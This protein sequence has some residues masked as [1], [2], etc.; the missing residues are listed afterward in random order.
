MKKIWLFVL[1]F[2]F[3]LGVLAQGIADDDMRQ[4]FYGAAE[5]AKAALKTAPFGHK[6]IAILPI[7]GD[8]NSLLMGRL[9]NMLTECGFSCVEGKED[10]MWNEI[11][12][13]IAWDE[14]KEDILDA[15]TIVKFGKLKAAQIL[16]YGKVCVYDQNEE[17]IYM[18]IELHAT[19][20]NTKQHIWGGNFAYR[21]YKGND[22]RGIISLDTELRLLLKK[23]FEEAKNSLQT[24]VF[25]E[26]LKNINTIT[27]IPLAGDIDQYMTGLAIEMLAQTK[28][29]PKNPQIPS[30]SQIRAFARDGYVQSDAVFYGAIRDLHQDQIEESETPDKKVISSYNVYADIQLFAEDVKTGVIL[31][32]KTITLKEKV[33]KERPMTKEEIERVRTNKV[34]DIPG[35]VQ[36]D[37]ID[38]WKFYA[39]LLGGFVCFILML[40][41]FVFVVKAFI[42]YNNVR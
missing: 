16:L 37:I 1:S 36:E 4:A 11:I 9:K 20:I 24:P 17:R 32:S 19:D 31:W 38:N 5:Q 22:I 39:M 29:S 27:V 7:H 15:E 42:S 3:T 34:E 13:E 18:E 23:N 25:A 2:C 28:H 40:L 12:K 6:N 14:R 21:F 10:P 8:Y 41:T 35:A 33:S 30:L 26:K